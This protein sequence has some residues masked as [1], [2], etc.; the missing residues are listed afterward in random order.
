MFTNMLFLVTSIYIYILLLAR[1]VLQWNIAFIYIYIYMV[2][3][4]EIMKMFHISYICE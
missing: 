1:K 2:I 3:K 4:R